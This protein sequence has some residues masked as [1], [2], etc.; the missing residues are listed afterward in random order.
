[1]GIQR[2]QKL[3]QGLCHRF[4]A[5]RVETS[6]RSEHAA[7]ARVVVSQCSEVKL[8]N[9]AS[10]VVPDSQFVEQGC[11]QL[12][13]FILAYL[14]PSPELCEDGGGLLSLSGRAIQGFE[15]VIG[16]ATPQLVKG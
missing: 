9:P 14:Y 2:I 4:I 11:P 5:N 12:V 13:L 6:V 1:L 7:Q 8:L 3:R 16:K 15:S 10:I